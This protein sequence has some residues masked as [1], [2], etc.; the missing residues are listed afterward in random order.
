MKKIIALTAPLLIL[1][2]CNTNEV[3]D[4]N[5]LIEQK[6]VEGLRARQAE[7][8]NQNNLLKQELNKVMDAIDRLDKDKKKSLVTVLQL[9]ETNFTHTV[10]LQGIV[11]ADQNMLLNA[12]YAGTVKK[13]HVKEGQKVNKGDLLVTLDDGGLAQN[14]ALQ[15]VQLDLAKTL[16]DRQERLWAQNIGAEIDYLQVKA[17]YESQKKTYQQLQQQ[18][19]KSALYAPF[20]GRVDDVVVEVGELVSPGVSPLLRLINLSNMYVEADVPEAYFPSINEQ[21]SATIEIPVF[22]YSFTSQ[23]THKGT[24]INTGN[25]TFR[26]SLATDNAKS[27]APNLITTVQL[28]DY[29][30]PSA[31]VVPLDVISENFDGAQYVYVVNSDEK[32]ENVLYKQAWSKELM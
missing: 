10:M 21:T 24:H 14:L 19:K 3:P 23:V 28:V 4:T 29:Q 13:I 20:S 8:V 15:K 25:R 22:D 2:G 32:A 31:I 17:A 27:L 18:L 6:N 11:K 26:V 5:V 16:Y 7:L 12:E 1:V 30:N 9:K